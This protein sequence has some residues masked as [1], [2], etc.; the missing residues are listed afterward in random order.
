MS[1]E[2]NSSAIALVIQAHGAAIVEVVGAQVVTDDKWVKVARSL[3]KGGVRVEHLSKPKEKNPNPHYDADA[4]N[5][6]REFVIAGINAK[7]KLEIFSGMVDKYSFADIVR[8]DAEWL[9]A[10]DAPDSF[11][12]VRSKGLSKIDQLIRKIVSYIGREQN[13]DKT[14]GTKP[15]KPDVVKSDTDPTVVLQGFIANAAKMVGAADI[16]RFQDSLTEAV[17]CIRRNKA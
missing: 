11:R 13:P 2:K 8:T 12:A 14:R 15:A 1:Q 3:F 17:A 7:K 4:Y 10:N 5:A 16:A 6:A 9:R